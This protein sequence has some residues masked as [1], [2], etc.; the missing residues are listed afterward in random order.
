M[1]AVPLNVWVVDDDAAVRWVL[2]K[3]LKAAGI[4]TRTFERAETFF[5]A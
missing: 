1:N 2:D 3:A 4:T 5:A